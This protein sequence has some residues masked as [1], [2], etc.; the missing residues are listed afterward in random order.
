MSNLKVAGLS[1][2]TLN[3]TQ[4]SQQRLNQFLEINRD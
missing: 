2:D 4:L 3:L 1:K